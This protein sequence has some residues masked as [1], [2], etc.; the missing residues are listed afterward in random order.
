[1]R[2][3]FE[4]DGVFEALAISGVCLLMFGAEAGRENR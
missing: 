1:M 4:L 3:V 2:S